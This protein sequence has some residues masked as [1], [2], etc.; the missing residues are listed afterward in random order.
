M[1]AHELTAGLITEIAAARPRVVVIGDL[2]LDGWWD[3]QAERMSREAPAPVVEIADRRFAAGGAANT[4]VNLAAMGANVRLIGVIG[5]DDAGR[6][7]RGILEDAGVD[8]RGVI[9]DPSAHTVAKNRVVSEEHVLVRLDDVNRAEYGGDILDAVSDAAERAAAWADAEVICD[10]GCGVLGVT[11]RDRLAARDERPRPCIV[12]AHDLTRM[13]ELEPD[14]I[15]PNA[16]EFEK[17]C[18]PLHPEHRADDVVRCRDALRE[19]SGADAAIVTLDR[20]GS[21][22]LCRDGSVHR[23]FA[24]PSHESHASGA[25][26]T[27][28]AGLTLGLAF[29]VPLTVAADLAQLA[30]DI[31]VREA[32]TSVC[33]ERALRHE[34][35]PAD[36]QTLD[37]EDLSDAIAAHREEGRR[38]VFTNGCFDVL[39]RGHTASLRQA[40][41]L[42]DVLIVAI[43]DDES[44]RRLKGPDRPVNSASDRAAVL[45]ALECVDYVTVFSTDTPIPLLEVLKP[46]VYAKGGDYT[47]E[48]LS[49]T[50]VVRRYGGTVHVLD[51]VDAHSTSGIVEQ[52]REGRASSVPG[53]ASS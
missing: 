19:A 5:S 39:H 35:S 44:V 22:A 14:V 24:H 15:T 42:G 41:R 49:E 53:G 51:Y 30:A 45:A 13:R 17:L 16:S 40:K 38:V 47:P 4:A 28:T 7:L 32:G 9:E 12:D 21:V 1:T 37:A 26:D 36:D 25:G 34:L 27:F 6:R 31:V 46:D 23:T 11:V 3:G 50:A 52:I 33:S 43:N 48:M 2:I 29:G 8:T 10:Y 20:E 18:G